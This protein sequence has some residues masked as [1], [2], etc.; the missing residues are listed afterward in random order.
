[1]LVASR[2]L[3]SLAVV[4][5]VGASFWWTAAHGT[6]GAF[7]APLDDVYI[8]FDF[9]RATGRGCLL[10]HAVGNGYSTGATSPTYALVLALGW[11]VGFRGAWLGALA[12]AIAIASLFDLSRS[13]GKLVERPRGLALLA[14][15]ALVAIPHLS[16]SW[17]SGMEAA[18]AGAVL[19]RALVA[20]RRATEAPPHVRASAQ[21]RAGA[22]ALCLALSRPECAP[23]S[24]LLAVA[25]AHG[26]GSRGAV[27]ALFRA[28]LPTALGLAGYAALAKLETGEWAAAGA[29]RKLVTYD[30]YASGL[31]VAGVVAKNAVRLG[32]EGFDVALGGTWS[33][34]ILGALAVASLLARTTR[35]LGAALVVGAVA[36]FFLACTNVTAPFQNLRYL[37]PTWLMLVVA[38]LLGVRALLERAR[39]LGWAGALGLLGALG[40][41]ARG[42]PREREHFALASKNIY[43]QQVEV[44]KR[45]GATTPKPR[46]ILVGDAGA[47]AYWSDAPPLDG[48]GLGGY[49]DLPFARAS[50][51]GTPAVVELIERMPERERPD[52]LAIYDAWWP[53]LGARFG[54]EFFRVRIDDNV[55]CADPEK[56]VYRA[57]W[58]KLEDRSAILRGL[59]DRIDLGD[60][61]DEREHH[62]AFTTPHAGYVVEAER[63]DATGRS[64][65]DAGRILAAGQWLTFDVLTPPPGPARIACVTDGPAG[66]EIVLAGPFEPIRR[67][68]PPIADS[69]WGRV[70]FDVPA[71]PAGA[72]LRLDVARGSFRCFS[73]EMAPQ[74][75]SAPRTAM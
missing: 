48:L 30:V 50:V 23:L 62:V 63:L 22:W 53:G 39:P 6:P 69:T 27:R 41:A 1:L 7:P 25:V 37:V 40:L 43:E 58:S 17:F 12:G 36:A 45:L 56:A 35:R 47:I 75:A 46:R 42:M 2:G 26:S 55:I 57:D 66:G 61:V 31:D 5:A 16:W 32:T 15:V 72:R 13:I 49:H 18:F 52:T 10:C 74:A 71:L 21:W 19:G 54:R 60:L 24:L 44:G 20:T 59:T 29:L 38:A 65:W 68:V 73:I 51:Q 33:V 9:A 67:A 14:P 70:S 8:Y 64:V 11:L 4:G 3:W 28:A 34:R